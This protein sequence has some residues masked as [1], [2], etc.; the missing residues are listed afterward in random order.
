MTMKQQPPSIMMGSTPVPDPT[1]LTTQQLEKAIV[2]SREIVETRVI[3]IEKTITLLQQTIDRLPAQREESIKQLQALHEEKFRSIAIQ[4]EER[5]TRTGLTSQ[6]T[7]KA[8]AAALQAAKEAV[9][10]QNKSNAASIQK[11]EVN[12][13]KQIDQIQSMITTGQ[14][15]N[16]D[17][18]DDV[19]TRIQIIESQKKGSDSTWAIIAA[20]TGIVI[21]I[22]AIAIAAVSIVKH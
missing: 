6:A 17:K 13:T 16:D 15:T 2:A 1:V 8:I 7:E 14:K 18:F 11:S 9:G 3:G 4:F 20:V 21:A 19:K 5:D 12:F 22:V 10:E